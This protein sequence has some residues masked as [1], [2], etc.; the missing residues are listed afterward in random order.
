M[1]QMAPDPCAFAVKQPV[2]AHIEFG[3][4]IQRAEVA[5]ASR[6]VAFPF[7]PGLD[8]DTG[9]SRRGLLRQSQRKS[10]DAVPLS[11]TKPERAIGLFRVRH[12]HLVASH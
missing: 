1:G 2:Y 10:R 5:G 9:R 11:D 8:R 6:S 12:G 4:E 7:A 3:S